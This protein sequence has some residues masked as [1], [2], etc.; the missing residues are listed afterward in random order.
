MRKLMLL[1]FSVGC[2]GAISVAI[3]LSAH[4]SGVQSAPISA[5]TP[6]PAVRVPTFT[7]GPGQQS[8]PGASLTAVARYQATYPGDVITA[9]RVT[10]LEPQ[11]PNT[12]KRV[13]V[14]RHLDCTYAYFRIATTQ[15]AFDALVRTLSPG[16][17]VV[18]IFDPESA[19]GKRPSP[20]LPAS[21]TPGVPYDAQGRPITAS[22][23]PPASI[24]P[25][26]AFPLRMPTPSR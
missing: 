2:I 7:V 16:D 18:T 13:I 25:T 22:A 26:P 21:L 17:S 24:P 12:D 1:L 15:Q 19:R 20:N 23:P 6:T 3:Y 11:I 10:D 9:S 14:V 5:C 8:T 4:M